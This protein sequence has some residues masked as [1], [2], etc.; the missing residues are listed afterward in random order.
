MSDISPQT[1]RKRKWRNIKLQYSC[2]IIKIMNKSMQIMYCPSIIV[3]FFVS[4][5]KPFAFENGSLMT[6]NSPAMTV[7]EQLELFLEDEL[8]GES[9]GTFPFDIS[10]S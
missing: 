9:S 6:C 4:T 7:A 5:D 3:I 1:N 2:S 8:V 10:P